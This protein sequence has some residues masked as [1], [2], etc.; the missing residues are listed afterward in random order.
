MRTRIGTAGK[1]EEKRLTT[2]STDDGNRS[3]AFWRCQ[4]P[5]VISGKTLEQLPDRNL[6][7]R[8][9]LAARSGQRLFLMGLPV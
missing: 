3:N 7:D 1:N 5:D 2:D 9:M 8:L 4:S 6:S